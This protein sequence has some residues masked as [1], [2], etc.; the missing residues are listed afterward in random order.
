MPCAEKV[1]LK[2]AYKNV[3]NFVR[4]FIPNQFYDHT[5]F[6]RRFLT[7]RSQR[8]Q[9]FAK[10]FLCFSLRLFA[11]FATFASKKF[12]IRYRIFTF[13]LKNRMS[14]GMLFLSTGSQS[15]GSSSFSLAR[16]VYARLSSRRGCQS[17]TG[18]EPSISR[19]WVC[20]RPTLRPHQ[21]RHLSS[22]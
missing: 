4:C 15:S 19:M 9:R 13:T 16:T 2:T 6:A 18:V 22:P 14:A 1:N 7:Q 21:F 17:K 8:R 20:Q 5:V 11:S 10:I 12:K 3:Y